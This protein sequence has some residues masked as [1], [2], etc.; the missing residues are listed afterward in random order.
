M[1]L[2]QKIVAKVNGD[3]E[4]L[5]L[6][7]SSVEVLP[8]IPW[9]DHTDLFTPACWKTQLWFEQDNF[10]YTSHRIGKT[11]AE[12]V[13][14]CILGGYGIP[15]EVGLAA[16]YKLREKGMFKK[17]LKEEDILKI[18]KKPL[19][20]NNKQVHYRFAKQK[21][22]YLSCALE[23]V[24]TESPPIK[25]AK[26]FRSWLMEIKGVGLK[27]ASWITR[28]WLNSDEIAIIDIHI[29][30]AGLLMGIYDSKQSPSKNYLEMEK[31]FLELAKSMGVKASELDAFIWQ[32]MKLAGNMVIRRINK[33]TSH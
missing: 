28:N 20:I 23:K 15:A 30:R 7:N 4:V 32:E 12:E 3:M 25:N 22:K 29:H 16:F 17:A 31:S 1:E 33:M 9:G 5:E 11:L 10:D 14:A 19:E 27:T 26:D 18:L 21:A 13:S 6:P 2:G 8:G 24:F